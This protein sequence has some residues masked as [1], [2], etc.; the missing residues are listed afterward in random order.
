MIVVPETARG[1]NETNCGFGFGEVPTHHHGDSVE[2]ANGPSIGSVPN[3][4]VNG[5]AGR[6]G[7]VMGCAS[8]TT[9]GVIAV[10]AA[11]TVAATPTL[12]VV[13]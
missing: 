4:F 6:L 5:E 13:R 8:A 12:N 7:V 11:T 2:K 1:A 9:T 3:R 10:A